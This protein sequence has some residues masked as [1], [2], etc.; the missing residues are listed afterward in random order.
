ME[1]ATKVDE[2]LGLRTWRERWA[3][4]QK[5]AIEF[6]KFLAEEFALRMESLGYLRTPLH[7][8]KKVRTD[9]KNVPLYYIAMFSKHETAHELWDEVL[10]YGTDQQNLFE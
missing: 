7:R 1:D 3:G 5:K 10:K 6:P 4:A 2:F 9:E 8:M